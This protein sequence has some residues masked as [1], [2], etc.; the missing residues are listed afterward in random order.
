MTDA[1][2]AANIRD[3]LARAGTALAAADVLAGEHLSSDA[4]SRL[5]YHL[6]YHVR[7]L[8][9]TKGIEARSHDGLLRLFGMHFVKSGAFPPDSAHIVSKLMKYRQEADYNPAHVFTEEDFTGLRREACDLAAAI[10]AHVAA[11]GYV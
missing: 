9:L 7:A 1:N 4:V 2:K 5:Y 10:R 11:A 6:F 3:E 8:L